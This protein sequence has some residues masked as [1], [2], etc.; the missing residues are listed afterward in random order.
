MLDFDKHRNE[1]LRIWGLAILLGW[2]QQAATPVSVRGA[3]LTLE[4]VDVDGQPLPCRIHLTDAQGDAQQARGFPFWHDHFVCPGR[5]QLTLGP[6]Q[7]RYTIERGPEYE[8][9]SGELELD[10]RQRSWEK[11]T[12]ERLVEMAR[13]GWRS[14]DLHVHRPIE[15]IPLHLQAEDL[16]IAPVITWWNGQNRWKD[17]PLPAE[18]TRPTGEGR[19]YD[20]MAGEDERDGGALLYFGLNEPLP[21]PGDRKEHPEHPSPMD[22]VRLA[23]E[24]SENVWIDVE[25]PFWWDVPVWVASGQVQSIGLA[26]NHMCRSTMFDN[27]AWG[28]PRDVEKFPSPRG[29]GYWTQ[30]IYY[31]LLN[32]GLRIPP[33]AGSASG[34]LPNPVGYNRVY[35]HVG[36]QTSYQDWWD[37]LAAGRCFVT[38]G[39]LLVCRVDGKLPGHVF[40]LAQPRRVNVEL[41]LWSNDPVSAVEIIQNGRVVETIAWDSADPSPRNVSLQLDRDGWFLARVIADHPETFRFASTGPFYVEQPGGKPYLDRDAVQFFVD[42]RQEREAAIR[43]K[44]DDPE[45]LAELLQDHAAAKDF[46]QQRLKAAES[47]QQE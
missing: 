17:R 7:Y 5:V 44:V 41:Q 46:W 18:T 22:Y 26:N 47:S 13:L 37:G 33:S 4:V 42:W 31:R 8:R 27:E 45:Q 9:Y 14:G 19:Y 29:N 15:E 21:L 39:P 25:K 16:H 10:D 34:V 40:K 32:C 28:K 38:N 6:G 35:V 3:V 12:L 1:W 2:S 20:V 11:I 23:R 36:Q 30:E 24:R 43:A